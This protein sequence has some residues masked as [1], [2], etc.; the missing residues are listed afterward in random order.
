[1]CGNVFQNAYFGQLNCKVHCNSIDESTRQDHKHGADQELFGNT[2]INF[3]QLALAL[4]LVMLAEV[5]EVA[6]YICS[7]WTKVAL[8]CRYVNSASWQESPT[9]QKCIGRVLQCRCRLLKHWKGKMSQCSILVLRPGR[10]PLA[11]LRR[12]IHLPEEKKTVPRAVKAAVLQAL[13][14]Y[15]EGS[16]SNGVAPPPSRLLGR[17]NNNLIWEFSGTKGTAHTMLVCHIATSILE[18]RVGSVS[19]HLSDSDHYIAATHFSRYCAYILGGSLPRATP[20][21]RRLV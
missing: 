21:R 15:D 20:R 17:G 11:L 19:Q 8:I 6:S 14:S 12:L 16:R 10:T 4:V 5:R 13:R 7:N 18:V 3:V 9:M 1:V 2:F